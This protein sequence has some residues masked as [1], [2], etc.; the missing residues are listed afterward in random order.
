MVPIIRLQEDGGALVLPSS[1]ARFCGTFWSTSYHG[2]RGWRL[3]QATKSYEGYYRTLRGSIRG[4]IDHLD[5]GEHQFYVYRPPLGLQR[6]PH[7]LCFLF[8]GNDMYQVH[9]S[10]QPK[11]I[12]DG[13]LAIEMVLYEMFGL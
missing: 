4:K 11:S 9:F 7:R 1:R 12:D 3:N 2:E 13:I 10:L 6:H 8:R 5:G